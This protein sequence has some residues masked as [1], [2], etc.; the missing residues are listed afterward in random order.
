MYQNKALCGGP[1]TSLMFHL[2]EEEYQ[3]YDSETNSYQQMM[4]YSQNISNYFYER[5]KVETYFEG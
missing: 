5:I 1:I 3:Y 4:I 2:R